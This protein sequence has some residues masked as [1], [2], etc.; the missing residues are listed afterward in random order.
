ME[1]KKIPVKKEPGLKEIPEN[2][3]KTRKFSPGD[4][5]PK[6]VKWL[7]EYNKRVWLQITYD[8]LD[9]PS[10]EEEI[11]QEAR[12]GVKEEPG[13]AKEEEDLPL[14]P[15]DQ[16]FVAIKRP[17]LGVPPAPP[18]KKRSLSGGRSHAIN[19]AP[20][21]KGFKPDWFDRIS[22]VEF[23]LA[24]GPLVDDK[25][26]REPRSIIFWTRTTGK[27]PKGQQK[28]LPLLHEKVELVDVRT[29]EYVGHGRVAERFL[30][31][32]RVMGYVALTALYWDPDAPFYF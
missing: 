22:G 32:K 6:A 29:G 9:L 21:A 5:N 31:A 7:Q 23:A 10:L 26:Q 17:P 18:S 4:L 30:T 28:T 15:V 16:A 13:E 27:N 25:K 1:T 11:K 20:N 14:E 12:D 2:S 19:P 24:L 3:P 8:L